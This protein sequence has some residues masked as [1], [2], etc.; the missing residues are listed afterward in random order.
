MSPSAQPFRAFPNN[1]FGP[2]LT[3]LRPNS[4]RD[5]RGQIYTPGDIAN[6]IAELLLADEAGHIA[7]PEDA[8][9]PQ[10]V[11]ARSISTNS[12]SRACA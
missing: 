6:A 2:L 10:S 1:L 11:G 8:T 12:P 5:A 4:A 7:P 9:R 3:V